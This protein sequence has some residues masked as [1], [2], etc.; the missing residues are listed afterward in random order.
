[1]SEWATNYKGLG[2]YNFIRGFRL[3]SKRR[4]LHPKGLV[5]PGHTSSRAYNRG[6]GFISWG[7]AYKRHFKVCQTNPS[8][9]YTH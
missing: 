9:N 4:T 3:A 1:M 7:R 8:A 2:L 6:R 5:S